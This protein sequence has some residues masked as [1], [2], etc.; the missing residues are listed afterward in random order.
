LIAFEVMNPL[1]IEDFLSIAE[2]VLGVRAEAL[3]H[4]TKTGLAESAL[5]APFASHAGVRAYPDVKR[6]AAVLCSHLVRN[7]PL[8][9]GNKRVAYLCMIELIRRNGLE[10]APVAGAEE[11]G[12]VIEALAAGQLSERDFARWVER[13]VR[14]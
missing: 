10:W 8:P 13:Q 7:H 5:A 1:E 3:R 9:D 14:G 6:K 4:A 2:A 12:D 11:R